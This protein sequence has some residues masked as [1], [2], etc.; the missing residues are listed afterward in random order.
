MGS[1]ADNQP[2]GSR[3]RRAVR[4]PGSCTLCDSHLTWC[5]CTKAPGVQITNKLT[6]M[7]PAALTPLTASQ[8]MLTSGPEVS[9]A[10]LW[11]FL[12]SIQTSPGHYLCILHCKTN[13]G[14]CFLS[15][16]FQLQGR[17]TFYASV[18]WQDNSPPLAAAIYWL[19][20]P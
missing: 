16:C 4:P 11:D 5:S 10:T 18:Q 12:S 14:Q 17:T 20:I 6:F 19:P 15:Y 13:Q 9:I 3:F 8:K 2:Y 7:S 1:S